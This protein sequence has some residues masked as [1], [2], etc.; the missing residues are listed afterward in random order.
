MNKF[1]IVLVAGLIFLG[2]FPALSRAAQFDRDLYYGLQNDPG[3]TLLQQFLTDQK[4]YSGPVTGNFF[5]LTQGAVKQF[6]EKNN[7][8]PALGYFGPKTR[9]VANQI[10][11][12]PALTLEQ[13]IAVLLQT[14]KELQDQLAQLQAA[15]QEA[16]PAPL[17]VVAPAPSLPSP[18]V[19][20]LKI[21]PTLSPSTLSSY[22]LK[23][24]AEFRLIADEKIGITKMRFKNSG[25][26]TDNYTVGFKL[27]NSATSEVLATV[28]SPV[29]KYIEFKMTEDS[30]KT[31]KGLAVSG[32]TYY[33]SAI[34]L[35]P[36]YGAE[37][38][39]IRLELELASD[40][41]AFDFNDLN[42]VADISATNVFPIQGPKISAF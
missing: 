27:I 23:T 37:K 32:N 6:Q 22:G 35:T 17:P 34:L 20:T 14:V 38:P 26:F 1:F 19:S 7:I 31:D 2:G 11:A 5:S 16:A 12:A 42:R 3:V 25:T 4:I 18:F 39:Y 33:I 28:E 29:D 10:G 30:A 8:A 21:E 36:S 15:E 24:L 41:S 13:Q 9:A 40:I